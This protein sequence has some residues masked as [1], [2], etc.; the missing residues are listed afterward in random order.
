LT[1]KSIEINEKDKK[2]KNK[3][4]GLGLVMRKMTVGSLSTNR[5]F[6]YFLE[7]K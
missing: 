6:K 7:R 3:R 4:N 5:N 2:R 1:Q